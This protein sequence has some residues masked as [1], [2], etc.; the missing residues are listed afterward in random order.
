MSN[1]HMKKKRESLR[2]IPKLSVEVQIYMTPEFHRLI[3][4][5]NFFEVPLEEENYSKN[6]SGRYK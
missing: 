5:K 1:A 2:R 3:I 4:L 6:S